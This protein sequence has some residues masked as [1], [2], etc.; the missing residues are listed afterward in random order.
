MAL[1]PRK[2]IAL[3]LSFTLLFS[4]IPVAI[5]DDIATEDQING[6]PSTFAMIGDTLIARPL[7][8]ALTAAGAAVFLVT[9][10]FTALGGNMKESANTLVIG[11][12]KATFT[13][14]LG[15]TQT[16]DEWKNK[17]TINTSESTESK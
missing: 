1:L 15:C 11:P 5:A 3:M 6:R 8:L 2:L 7:L 13:R 14:C 9:V 12:A 4:L 10:P 16:Q 17:D